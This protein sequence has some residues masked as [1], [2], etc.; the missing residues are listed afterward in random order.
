MPISIEWTFAIL[1]A[2]DEHNKFGDPYDTVAILI[3]SGDEYYACAMAGNLSM[4]TY[5][6]FLRLLKELGITNVKWD[7]K[8]ITPRKVK[9]DIK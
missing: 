4:K 5:R 2:G 6:E 7:K 3:K 9:K 1:R 8:N